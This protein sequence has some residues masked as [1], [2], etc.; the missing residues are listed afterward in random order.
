[1]HNNVIGV[2]LC[3]SSHYGLGELINNKPAS[4]IEIKLG[5]TVLDKQIFEYKC[6]GISS[7]ILISDAISYDALIDISSSYSGI[8]VEVVKEDSNNGSVGAL[9]TAK[10]LS[11]KDML[12][13]NSDVVT[14]M[15]MNKI[16]ECSLS[17]TFPI[18]I[19][20]TMLPSPYGILNIRGDTVI[21]FEEKPLIDKRINA[22]IYFIKNQLPISNL[23]RK[24]KIEQTLFPEYANNGMMGFYEENVFWRSIKTGVDLGTVRKE[25]ETKIDKAWG[26]EKML[27]HTDKYMTKELFIRE[28]FHTSFH[29]HEKKDETMYIQSGRGYIKFE[30]SIEYFSKN[31]NI[32]IE[33]KTPHS[34]V[35]LSNTVL[36]EFSTPHI[37]DTV[38]LEDYYPRDTE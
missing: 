7:V 13:R 29:H 28:G 11:E 16:I 27:V 33:P 4:C 19:A 34:I 30:D 21:G 36:Y 10:A 9:L 15:N 18:I 31:D 8:S 20:T 35:A 37:E 26:Y 23:Y 2:I 38:R 22:G 3:G 1:M 12:V 5:Y 6:A 17:S 14:D 24:G 32:R 25:Y